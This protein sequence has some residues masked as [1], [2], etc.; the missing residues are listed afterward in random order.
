MPRPLSSTALQALFA[1]DTE[2][3]FLLLVK[4]FS[5]QTSETYRCALN[6]ED[7]LSNGF[8]FVATYFEVSLPEIS[9]AAPAGC[10]I[11]VDN[12]DRR[13]VGMLRAITQPLQVT[14]QVVL[15][16]TP[17]V[18]EMEY[19]DLIL[20]EATWDVSKI[21]GKLVSEDPLNQVFPGHLYEPRTFEGL[22]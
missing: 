14:L 7:V 18:V 4:F 10:Q 8:N 2:Q 20:R 16:G 3:A 5:P 17:D 9:D 1:Q 19:T 15:S 21:H 13:L 12:V 22:F 11:S 6:T